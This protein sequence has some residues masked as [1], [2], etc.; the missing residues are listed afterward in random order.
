MAAITSTV[1]SHTKKTNP[2][3][4]PLNRIRTKPI[5]EGKHYQCNKTELNKAGTMVTRNYTCQM[6]KRCEVGGKWVVGAA[7]KTP[8][9]KGNNDYE[10]CHGSLKGYFTA[11]DRWF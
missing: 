10:T 8:K 2:D 4:D 9:T 6:I 7:N 5:Y 3:E 1:T 11:K